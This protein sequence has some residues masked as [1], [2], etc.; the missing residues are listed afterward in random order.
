M[1][2]P[3]G[4]YL[5]F[6][7]VVYVCGSS[8]LFVAPVCLFVFLICCVHQLFLLVVLFRCFLRLHYHWSLSLVWWEEEDEEEEEEEE[9][10]EEDAEGEEGKEEEE[11]EEEEEEEQSV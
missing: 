6:V 9:E 7:S 10:D 11:D 5:R 8:L 4:F 1:S 2:V 3:V